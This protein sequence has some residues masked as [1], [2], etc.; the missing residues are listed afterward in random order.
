MKTFQLT[1]TYGERQAIDWVGYRYSHG[2][3]L[4][5][6]LQNCH[7]LDDDSEKS[8]D[9]IWDEREDICFTLG[10]EQVQQI[11]KMADED[12]FACFSEELKHK[13]Y[14]LIHNYNRG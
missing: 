2:D 5:N 10:E 14:E 6:L 11:E 8:S 12:D 7:V 4:R 3:D 1:L 9:E 13:F